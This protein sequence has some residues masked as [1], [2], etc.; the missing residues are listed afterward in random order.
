MAKLPCISYFALSLILH[1]IFLTIHYI[2]TSA[3]AHLSKANRTRK[4]T[5][6]TVY[7]GL[8]NSGMHPT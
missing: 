5:G 8:A 6:I 2:Q 3:I 1:D 7:Q 4:A